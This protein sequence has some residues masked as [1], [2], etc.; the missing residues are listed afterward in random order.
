MK[1]TLSVHLQKTEKRKLNV[2][3]AFLTKLKDYQP[4]KG[5]KV[6][7]NLWNFY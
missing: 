6:K 5:R 3:T 1:E 2:K 4:D 7:Q